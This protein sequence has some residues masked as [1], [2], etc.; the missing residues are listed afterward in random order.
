LLFA[1][2]IIATQGG[3]NAAPTL[4]EA[5][6]QADAKYRAAPDV[7]G[8]DSAPKIEAGNGN[9]DAA[10]AIQEIAQGRLRPC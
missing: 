2:V 3:A 5:V 10:P 9:D 6:K 4:A 1:A 7:A 8:E